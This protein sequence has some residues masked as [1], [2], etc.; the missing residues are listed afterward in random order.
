MASDSDAI[1]TKPARN[2][3]AA[4]PFGAEFGRGSSQ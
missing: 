2:D 3:L 4:E 1:Q